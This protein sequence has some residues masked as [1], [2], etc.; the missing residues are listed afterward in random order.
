MSRV[1]GI[2][3]FVGLLCFG[4]GTLAVASGSIYGTMSNFDVYNETE[5]ESHGAEIEL[6]G[7]HIEDI[8]RTFPSNYD[9]ESI[10][11]YDDGTTF[12]TRI[13][14]TGY[15]LNPGGF[16]APVVNPTSTNGHT[17]VGTEGCE[18]FG[19]SVTGVQPIAA[20]YYWL[21]QNGQ[22]IGTMP[23]AVPTPTWNYL[24]PVNPGGAAR[25]RAEVEIPEPPEVI[26]QKPDSIWM[27]V[28][29]T[30]ID[31]P[32]DLLELMSNN[33]IV[34]EGVGE[35]E[36]EWELLEGGKVKQ[37][38]DDLGEGNFAVIRR[39][40]YFEYT[41]VYDAENEPI[42]LFLD[43][44]DLLEPPA[45]ELGQFISAN[46][47]AANLAAPEE[48]DFNQDDDVDGLDFLA[49]QRGFGN[50]DK[51]ADGDANWDDTVDAD[52]LNIWAQQYG[53]NQA[54]PQQA[55]PE[56]ASG[57][58]LVVGCFGILVTHRRKVVM[59]I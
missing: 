4:S 5:T 38:E 47:V 49:L 37:E 36:T 26:A 50:G 39:Y 1:L 29:K 56:P 24:A 54:P 31:R 20:R 22:R 34:P 52:D 19:F 27:K 10:A 17:C 15:N 11:E 30:E 35:M 44:G 9:N 18:H 40:E 55:V 45:G 43:P 7:I 16:L 12:G 32:V 51:L 6:E 42:T 53:G 13:I 14:Y 23:M 59:E 28:Y 58:L 41:G 33:G 3:S 21:D 2:T 48:G 8:Y 46:M 25:L 57:V